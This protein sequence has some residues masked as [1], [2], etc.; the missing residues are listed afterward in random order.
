MRSAGQAAMNL[1]QSA[2]NWIGNT[3]NTGITALENAQEWVKETLAK[4]TKAIKDF[5]DDAPDFGSIFDIPESDPIK[6]I[7]DAAKGATET[8]KQ[9]VQT[10][11]PT[12]GATLGAI[13]A[14]VKDVTGGIAAVQNATRDLFGELQK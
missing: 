6:A 1:A 10:A 8:V 4:W 13:E 2:A 3:I 5:K 14:K 9:V 11:A 7:K 12:I